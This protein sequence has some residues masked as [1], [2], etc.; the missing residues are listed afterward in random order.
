MWLGRRTGAPDPQNQIDLQL[1][2]QA[3]S[4]A[5]LFEAD[6][7]PPVLKAFQPVKATAV[8]RGL[9]KDIALDKIALQ[10]GDSQTMAIEATG[11]IGRIRAQ[12]VHPVSAVM[13]QG[14][15][16]AADPA[17]LVPGQAARLAALG[18]LRCD[19]TLQDVDGALRLTDTRVQVEGPSS[20][21]A[22][23]EGTWSA[24]NRIEF[25]VSTRTTAADLSAL[26]GLEGL[27]L[28]DF[29]RIDVAVKIARRDKCWDATTFEAR[30][31]G[32]EN[33]ALHIA[34]NVRDLLGVERTVLEVE[35]TGDPTQDVFSGKALKTALPEQVHGKAV[36]GR[37]AAGFTIERLV[38][39]CRGLG[40]MTGQMAGTIK[41]G[42]GTYAGALET[43]MRIND[44]EA[45]LAAFGIVYPQA[46]PV[47]IRGRVTGN[48]R[49]PS[50]KGLI[51]WGDNRMNTTAA[52]DL[53]GPKPKVEID[54]VA[55]AYQVAGLKRRPKITAPD[56]KKVTRK[57]G[58][59]LRRLFSAEP[60]DLFAIKDFD[61][62]LRIQAAQLGILG[63]N[64]ADVDFNVSQT[65]GRLRIDPLLFKYA[66]G[67]LD[68]NFVLDASKPVPDWFM[69]LKVRGIVLEQLLTDLYAKAEVGGT[70]NLAVN[71]KSQGRSP[72]DIAATLTG[73][74]GLAVEQGWLPQSA[75]LLAADVFDALLTLPTPRQRKELSCLVT[76][77]GFDKGLGT[78]RI[79]SMDTQDFSALGGG[80]IDLRNE[81]LDLLINPKQK[82]RLVLSESSPVRIFGPLTKLSFS[83]MPYREAAKLYGD[84]LM[85][86][87]GISDRVLG[88]LWDAVKPA[89]GEESP[90]YVA[91]TQ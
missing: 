26:P 36:I 15:L 69:D 66:G 82:K 22:A 86:V 84:I 70:L 51:A 60:L 53:S 45:L 71:I 56:S 37:D 62:T 52:I 35:F 83:K 13:L 19:F 54:A 11:A 59:K 50:F 67:E 63:F 73:D 57:Q 85:P 28:P 89:A 74:A 32:G 78:S 75:H 48:R 14:R 47:H 81:T 42:Q 20:I 55:K 8:L 27:A 4:A 38:V 23:V 6:T 91:P 44:P 49:R 77:F 21:Q 31:Y 18:T 5:A 88:F 68:L 2:L 64:L 80:T 40:N 87:I 3:P 9:Y 24:S 41:P 30:C 90:C 43:E 65:G 58:R 79:L 12:D 72:R 33:E 61:L 17:L 25:D 34:G 39:E 1:D 29:K 46:R 7:A 10:A 16:A 76:G